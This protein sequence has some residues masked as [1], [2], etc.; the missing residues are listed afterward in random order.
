VEST[1]H[2]PLASNI[3]NPALS[4]CV[5]CNQEISPVSPSSR[6]PSICA[7]LCQVE[8]NTG[9]IRQNIFLCHAC[10]TGLDAVGKLLGFVFANK[11]ASDDLLLL[12]GEQMERVMELVQLVGPLTFAFLSVRSPL[13]VDFEPPRQQ[14]PT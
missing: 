14:S 4:T 10:G 5:K 12:K 9:S 13:A 8:I 1:F 7:Y 3:P 11:E 6:F 2:R